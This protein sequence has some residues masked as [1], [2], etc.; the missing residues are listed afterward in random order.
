MVLTPTNKA[1]DVITTKIMECMGSDISYTKWLARFGVTGDENIENSNIFRDKTFDLRKCR[2][3]VTVTTI[4]RFAYD[5]FMPAGE[6][7]YIDA[8]NW[9]YIVIDEASMIPVVQ[10]IYP[11]FCKTPKKFV[12][13]GDPFQIAPVTTVNIWADEN[14]YTLTELN[15]FTAATTVPHDYPVVRLTTQY[16]STPEIGE[17]FSNFAYGGI[18]SHHRKSESRRNLHLDGIINMDSLNIIKFPVSKY[19]S[20]YRAKRLSGTTPYHIYSAIFTAEFA[21]YL[22]SAL[23]NC[24][25]DERFNIGVIAPYRAQASLIDRLMSFVTLPR[26]INVQVGTIHGFQG[27]ECDIVFVVLNTPPSISASPK[28]FLNRQN[29][30]NVAISRARDY[31]F[32]VMPDDRTDNVCRLRKIKRIEELMHRSGHFTEQT[33]AEIERLMFGDEKF[34]ESN[35]FA[36]SHQSV[37]VYGHPEKHY[38]IR[39]EDTAI[40][41]QVHRD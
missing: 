8:L 24:N 37:N 21:N 19:E 20:I 33:T 13:A 32:V 4:A 15:S 6:R 27:D 38:E 39:S 40:D 2:R 28:L 1:A 16:R 34:I 17:I 5:F 18:L 3:S 12:I 14:I 9:D 29:I 11:L 10:I 7:L 23:K 31:L 26:G 30:L 22:C 36:T 41:I 25:P 35:S